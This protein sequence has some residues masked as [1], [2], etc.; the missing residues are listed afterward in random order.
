MPELSCVTF[1][2]YALGL[3]TAKLLIIACSTGN[4][5]YGRVTLMEHH[6]AETDVPVSL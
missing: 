2:Y 4:T 5:K 3:S 6:Q 1:R